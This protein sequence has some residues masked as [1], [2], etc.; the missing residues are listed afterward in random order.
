[1]WLASRDGIDFSKEQR[2]STVATVVAGMCSA[3]A[4]STEALDLLSAEA[5]KHDDFRL[6]ALKAAKR[7][8]ASVVEALMRLNVPEKIAG[9]NL[10]PTSEVGTVE[11][12]QEAQEQEAQE[13]AWLV[14][15]RTPIDDACLDRVLEHVALRVL[16]RMTRAIQLTDFFA[17]CFMSK[18][19]S[20]RALA[21]SG[22][23]E[24]AAVC[25]DATS[26]FSLL[27]SS[28]MPKGQTFQRV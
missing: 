24:F 22:I 14:A 25:H 3:N 12:E 21:L 15:L 10:L 16:P 27:F 9:A 1:V 26:R 18:N 2:E 6:L 23:F 5:A 11:K 8:G 13:K 17:S 20:T 28:F 19:Y 4:L 7:G